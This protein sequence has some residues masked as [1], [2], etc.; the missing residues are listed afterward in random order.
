MVKKA[1]YE[2]DWCEK[3]VDYDGGD[4]MGKA[5]ED[6]WMVLIME[7]EDNELTFCSTDCLV[8]YL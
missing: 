4:A 3:R 6:G 1:V 7:P 2:C 8:S 5:A